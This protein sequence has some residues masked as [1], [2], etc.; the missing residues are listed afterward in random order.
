MPV[1]KTLYL[2]YFGL[3]EPLVQTQVVP[4]LRQLAA[5][6]I[7]VTLLTFEPEPPHG[8]GAGERERWEKGLAS[9]G[10]RWLWL[11][12]HK[13]PSVPATLY[14]IAAGAR[15]AARLVRR[16]GVEVLHARAHVPM[17]MA[18]AAQRLAPVC[19]TV[20][21]IRGLMAEEYADAGV[22]REGSLPY[23]LVKRLER[24]GIERS[25]QIVVLTR[26][27]RDWLVGQGMAPAEKIEVIPCCVDFAR[28]ETRGGAEGLNG[29]GGRFEVVYAGSVTGLYLLEEMGRFFAAV[30]AREPRAF[31]RVLTKSPPGEAAAVLGRAGLRGEDFW[32]GPATAAE[33]PAL[34]RLARVG[35]SF[36]KATFSQIAASPTK[37]PEYLAAGLPVVSNAGIGDTDELIEREGVGVVVRELTAESYAAAAGRALELAR[38]AGM[39]RRCE[40]VA[41]AHF[42]LA[43][44]GGARYRDVYGRIDKPER[45]GGAVAKAGG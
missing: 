3:R 25:D 14:D 41:R 17:A 29:G 32:V 4:Y 24:A 26:K 2:C 37:V 28:Y 43:R 36:R 42:D 35:V 9:G 21:D 45:G 15:L 20:F 30:K 40:E 18:L 39:A 38:A 16:E 27:M 8:W 34:L 22:W 19:R 13:S 23:R 31:M 5:G 33:V 6:G 12:Y 11:K 10:V 44:V 7:E 1:S